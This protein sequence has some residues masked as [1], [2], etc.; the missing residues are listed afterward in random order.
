MLY[1]A[2]DTTLPTCSDPKYTEIAAEGKIAA[3]CTVGT[4]RLLGAVST[5]AERQLHLDA[6]GQQWEYKGA[7]SSVGTGILV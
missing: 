4:K 6:K 5:G 2:A 1:G 3:V 7:S